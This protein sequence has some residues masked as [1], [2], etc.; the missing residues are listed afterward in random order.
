MPSAKIVQL[1]TIIKEKN[2]FLVA[3]FTP[4]HYYSLGT[5]IREVRVCISVFRGF[6]LFVLEAAPKVSK[7]VPILVGGSLQILPIS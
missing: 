7:R 2:E 4:R 3:K 1:G 6:Y 5:I